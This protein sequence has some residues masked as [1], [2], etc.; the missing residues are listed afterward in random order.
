[1]QADPEGPI[2]Q[3]D[4]EGPIVQVDPAENLIG[5]GDDSTPAYNA[6]SLE[7][8]GAQDN[9]SKDS[10]SDTIPNAAASDDALTGD[11]LMTDEVDTKMRES[12]VLVG[13]SAEV[14]LTPALLLCSLCIATGAMRPTVPLTERTTMTGADAWEDQYVNIGCLMNR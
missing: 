1:V 4:P 5:E 13:Q 11:D 12:K 8:E 2:V 10:G 14:S 6:A 9:V 3:A 7:G